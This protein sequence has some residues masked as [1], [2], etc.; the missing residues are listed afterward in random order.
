MA[1]RVSSNASGFASSSSPLT[2]SLQPALSSRAQDNILPAG[3]CQEGKGN[4]PSTTPGERKLCYYQN[5]RQY[6]L[7]YVL[8]LRSHLGREVLDVEQPF[9]SKTEFERATDKGLTSLP[10]TRAVHPD[11]EELWYSIHK[12][13]SRASSASTVDTFST[14]FS[15]ES[16]EGIAAGDCEFEN[17][18]GCIRPAD[19][20]Q[21]ETIPNKAE[22]FVPE[23]SCSTTDLRRQPRQISPSLVSP[24]TNSEISISAEENDLLVRGSQK[25]L[26]LNRLMSF[27][28]VSFS[29]CHSPFPASRAI[30]YSSSSSSNDN[31]TTNA[32]TTFIVSE[33]SRVRGNGSASKRNAD[34]N[35]DEDYVPNEDGQ[36]KKRRLC[37]PS[38]RLRRLACPY[39]KNNPIRFQTKQSCCGPGWETVHRLKEHLDRRHALPISCRRCYSAFNTEEEHDS[40]IRSSDQCEVRRRPSP[41]EGFNASQRAELKSRPRGLKHMSEPQKWRRVYLILFPETAE[42]EIPSPYYEFQTLN[43]PGH[44]Q[45]LMMEYEEYL[46]RELPPRVREQ[47]EIRIEQALDPIEETLRG[48]IV[49]IVRDMQL[50]LFR[51]FRSSI[52]QP[53]D[54]TT[55]R[56]ERVEAE[57]RMGEQRPD[58]TIQGP[59][60]NRTSL[61]T[62][63]S[64][65]DQLAA[66]RTE[67]YL[68]W[69]LDGFDGQLFDFGQV[70]LG[71]GWNDSPYG[72]GSTTGYPT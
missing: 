13:C 11:L 71:I 61:Q 32:R 15:Y 51:S 69:D 57:G 44:P 10:V 66:W 70:T 7:D 38:P 26:L 52:R 42:S 65:E 2:L 8:H 47:L 62:G 25:K 9:P 72:T 12:Q 39:F 18:F 20:P 24:Q 27:F 45:D 30:I 68:D 63:Q 48:Q 19:Q 50:E 28:F 58:E 5:G 23:P 60:T 56:V 14:T 59:L 3:T 55:Y 40:H 29:S 36:G 64:V 53:Y 43:D 31:T 54:T 46:Q 49:E 22:P 1:T 37:D 35:E 33:S 4:G 16:I 34:D 6:R 17:C 41:I 21:G 67:P